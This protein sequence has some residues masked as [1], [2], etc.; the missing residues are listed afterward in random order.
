[1]PPAQSES[2]L[3]MVQPLLKEFQLLFYISK[4]AGILPQDLEKFRTKNV[5][6][7]S[8]NGMVYMLAMLIVYVLLYNILIYSFGEEDRTLKASQS[9]LT[10]VIGLFLTYIGL[11]MMGT[12]QLT[13]LRNQGRIGELYERIRHVDERLY[14]E[15]C[16]VDNSHIGGR[17]RFMLIMTFLFELSILLATYIKLV[18]YTPMD[19]R[20]VDCLGHSHFHQ[21]A[22]Q[23]LVCCLAVCAEG[24]L[25]GHQPDAGRAGGHP[26]EVQAVAAG[27]S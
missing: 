12:D 6:E 15:K 14:K 19:V 25:R 23:D 2:A 7:K 8:R 5:L 16:V 26:R 4:I 3:P 1:M 13:A 17:I 21:Y 18:D 27:R 10:F 9:T 24:T 20:S 11:I 22:G